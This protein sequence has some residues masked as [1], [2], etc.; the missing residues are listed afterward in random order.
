MHP[1]RLDIVIDV[2]AAAV[3]TRVSDLM[4]RLWP[5]SSLKKHEKVLEEVFILSV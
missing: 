2:D 1:R 5:A 4:L 3:G